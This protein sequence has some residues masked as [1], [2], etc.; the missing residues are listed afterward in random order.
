MTGNYTITFNSV[1][2]TFQYNWNAESM[3][4]GLKKLGLD[5]TAE[6]TMHGHDIENHYYLVNFNGIKGQ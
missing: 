4:L 2:G 6:V 1:V 5:N 3:L